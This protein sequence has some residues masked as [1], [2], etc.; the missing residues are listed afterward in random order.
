MATVTIIAAS[1]GGQQQ[2]LPHPDNLS[3][4]K[5]R[6]WV[7]QRGRPGGGG[8]RARG[9][10]QQRQP[11][12][13]DTLSPEQIHEWIIHRGRPGGGGYGFIGTGLQRQQ[14][15]QEIFSPQR[16]R[17]CVSQR[18]A[19]GCVEA[20][21]LGASESAAAPGASESAA[22]LGASESAAN[23][24]ASESAAALGASAST[25]TGP[26]SAEALHTF[27]LD[28]GAS[29]CFFRDCT[30]VTPLTTPIPV[31]LADPT[32]GPVVER[33]STVLPCLA[34]P[35]GSLSGLHLPSFSTNVWRCTCSRT[36]RHLATFIRQPGSSLYT[37]TTASTQVAASGQVAAS[38]QVS[39]SGQLAASCSCQERYFLLVVDDYSRYTTVFPLRSKADVTRVLIPWIHAAC[40]QLCERFR[41]DLPVLRLH[42]DWGGEFSFGLLAEFCRDQGIVK[43]FMLPTSPHQN[44]IAEHRIGLVMELNL[45]PRVSLPE[46]SPTLRWT[47]EVGD[48][49][50]FRVW[51]ALSL[52]HN[53]TASKLSPRTLRSAFLGFP[54]DAPPWQFYYPRSSHVFSSQDVTLDESVCFYRLHPHASYPVDPPPL[55]EPLEISSDSSGPAEGDDPAADDTSTT[56]HSPRFKTPPGF[57][58]RPSSP[59]PQPATMDSVAGGASSRG[60]QTGGAGSG[61][62][63][64]GGADT[65]GAASPSGSGAVGDPTGGPG[66]GQPS[67][68]E[69]LSPQQ[70]REWIV[71]RSHPGGRGYSVTAFGAAGA[72]GTGATGTGGAWATGAGAAGPGGACTRGIGVAGATGAGGAG[73]AVGGAE[74]AGPGGACTGGARAARAGG[75]AGAR[76]A[77]GGAGGTRAAGTGGAGATGAG[78]A[79]AASPGGARTI[80]TGAAGVGGAAGAPGAT[81]AAGTGGAGAAGAGGA[82][83]AVGTRD[84]GDRG[85]G[86]TGVIDGMGTVPRRPFFY[87]QPQSSLPPPVSALRQVLS[88]LSYTRLTPPLLCP[89]IDQSQPQL[90]PAP[91]PHTE[92]IESLTER[93]EPETH[94]SIPVCA[95]RVARPRPPAVPGTHGMA[96]RPSSVPQRV[97]LPEPPASSLPH[98]PDPEFDLACATCPT[99][100]CL[101]AIVV[102]DPNLESTAAFVLVTELVDF[103]ARSR[104]DYVAG[105]V[106]KS[107]S[108]CPPSVGGEHALGSDVLEDRLFELECLA[109]VLPRFASM[110]LCLEG[111]LDAL[112]IPTPRSY[113]KAIVGEYSSQWQTAMDTEM[114]SCKS[115]S[116]YVD[117]VPPLGAN[118]VDGMWVFR[119][120]RPPGS[121]PAFKARYVARGFSHRQGVDYFQNFPP[122]LK[123]TTLWVLLHVAAQRDY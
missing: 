8:Y 1:R 90:V 85:T 9:A 41:R 89:P 122:T 60:A 105:L 75:A 123:M 81:G 36:G 23:L 104:L 44:G 59:P 16:L 56:R 13:P 14:R 29:R 66:V 118:I 109:V 11:E 80:V 74:A 45:W 50:A 58:P 73:G 121:P 79:G 84:V 25:A 26:A 65:G 17:D 3:Q 35:S 77:S 78:A 43:T 5:L 20:P 61:G 95:H 88:L 69:T 112:D 19:P 103:V 64:T 87:P 28:S 67:R 111:D 22:A 86:G 34:F 18:G 54:T 53:T 71:Q 15:Q 47:G 101:L 117:E 4:Q 62:A 24:G 116:T 92:V 49:S 120:K 68:L 100:T 94:A 83:G 63:E 38:S 96:L 70:I 31:S 113:A 115:T 82:G 12:H 57:P 108:V 27:T 107:E 119:V 72:G 97:V 39:A 30:T 52:V 55:V 7:I 33:A 2:P 93:R 46:T 76:G 114:A 102:T 99:V 21:A 6:E 48:A 98:V 37:L 106:T 110:L 40:L 32:G 42:S 10:G 51:G 91:T